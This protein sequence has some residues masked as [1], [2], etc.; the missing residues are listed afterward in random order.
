MIV[1]LVEGAGDKRALPILDER[2]H[3]KARL[4]CVDMKGKS[5][6]VRRQHGFEDTIRRQHALGERS[7]LVLVDGDVTAAPYRSLP[8]ERR[9][10]PRRAQ[11]IAGELGISVHVCWA[12]RELES[13]LIGGIEQR[14]TYCRLR[15]VGQ[16]PNNTETS[17]TRLLEA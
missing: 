16:V 7:F 3:G 6:I 15:N 4:R 14:S 12:V 9:D 1:V 10:L 17:T 11:A 13:W 2:A 5:N 8:E